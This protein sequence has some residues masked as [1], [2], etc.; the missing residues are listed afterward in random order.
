M[1]KYLVS[2]VKGRVGKARQVKPFE[3]E[4]AGLHGDLDKL[5]ATHTD[6]L[7]KYAHKKMHITTHL[8]V[9]G[10]EPHGALVGVLYHTSSGDHL[11][12]TTIEPMEDD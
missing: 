6:G 5:K 9:Q 7:R 3:I 10:E 8:V 4:Y 12:T 11:C 2:P 1:A